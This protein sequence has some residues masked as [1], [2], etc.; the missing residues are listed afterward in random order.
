MR[1][2][3]DPQAQF[4]WAC[5]R[6]LFHYTA[7][8]LADIAETARDVDFAIRWGY[9]WKLGP[10]ETWQAAG[11]QQVAEW[12]DEDIAAGKAMSNA[13][14]PAWVTDGRR[15]RACTPPARIQPSEQKR[16]ARV[17]SIRSTSASCSPIAL[18]GEK[19]DTGTTVWENDGVRLWTLGGDDVGIISFKTKMNTVNDQVLDG[20]QHAVGLAERQFK[21][22]VIWQ[23]GGRSPPVPTSRACWAC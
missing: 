18:I 14:L 17:R 4:L 3:V 7:Y 21:A 19:F 15:R 5:F 22:L 20:I 2:S 6:D 8:H 23:T 1:A 11:W 9:G 10:F 16:H 12:I 13:P